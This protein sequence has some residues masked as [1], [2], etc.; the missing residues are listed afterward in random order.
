MHSTRLHSF[1]LYVYHDCLLVC[2]C[3]SI[4]LRTSG[5]LYI[6][7]YIFIY[8]MLKINKWLAFSTFRTLKINKSHFFT[9]YRYRLF[10]TFFRY[11]TSWVVLLEKVRTLRGRPSKGFRPQHTQTE[12][13]G[14]DW[15]ISLRRRLQ[16]GRRHCSVP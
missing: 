13:Q 7:H 11:R 12:L 6:I 8:F 2:F 14:I 10:D 4:H 15:L 1:F 16:R 3:W 5:H 9:W